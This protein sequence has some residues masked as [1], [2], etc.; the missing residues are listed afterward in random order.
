MVFRMSLTVVPVGMIAGWLIRL[1]ISTA[2]A[3][4][5]AVVIGIIAV[6]LNPVKLQS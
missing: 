2:W 3:K 5:I 6:V 4:R 1:P